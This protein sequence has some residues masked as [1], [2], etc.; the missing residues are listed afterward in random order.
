MVD[1]A[2]IEQ[3]E[4]TRRGMYEEM[5][6]VAQASSPLIPLFQQIE[7]TAMRSNVDGFQAGGAV[8]SAYY[9]PVTKAAAQ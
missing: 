1:A 5:Q 2:V 4:A 3:D 6:R 9:W 7:Q 8:E